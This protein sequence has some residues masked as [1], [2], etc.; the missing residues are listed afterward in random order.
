MKILQIIATLL[1]LCSPA[2]ADFFQ[3]YIATS[4]P[5]IASIGGNGND[6]FVLLPMIGADTSTTFTNTAV[7]PGAPAFTAVGN[8]QID[9]G[10]T[11]PWA[12][13]PGVG[14]FDADGDHLS[15]TT[16]ADFRFLH[17]PNAV[18]S[19]DFRAKPSSFGVS[20][21]NIIDNTAG[22]SASVGIFLY[23]TNARDIQIDIVRGFAGTHVLSGSLGTYPNDTAGWHH[24]AVTCDLSLASNN[25]RLAIDGVWGSYLSKTAN[26]P[27]TSD[28]T[29]SLR[30]GQFQGGAGYSYD[31]AM[32]EF[33]IN[34]VIPAEYAENFTPKTGRYTTE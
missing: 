27:S 2:R 23:I 15:T 26:A 24:V 11:D 29:Y 8:A 9:T 21:I 25:V 12:L 32:A 18:W 1:L 22:S 28:P 16:A 5:G 10:Q 31:G 17:I 30:L 33:R 7:G 20:G 4:T 13:S 34:K 6:T 19:L 3:S 14:L